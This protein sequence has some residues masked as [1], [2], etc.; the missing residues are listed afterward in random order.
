MQ[1]NLLNNPDEQLA[2]I[3]ARTCYDS[4][5]NSTPERDKKLLER[6]IESGHESVIEH[7]VYTF[8]IEGISRACLQQLV[9]HRIASYSVESTRYTLKKLLKKP[10]KDLYVKTNN[11]FI[12]Q[13]IEE[14]LNYIRSLENIPN[15]TLKYLLP[16][17]YKTSLVF[18]INAR[19]LRNFLKL[20]LSKEAHWEIRDLAEKI[21]EIVKDSILFKGVINGNKNNSSLS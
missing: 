5:E 12:D 4:F 7:V 8:K 16:E 10:L 3:A 1:V 18:T 2:I 9:R 14:K 13:F 20:R 11:S 6:I 19:S 17:A 21:A 15:D